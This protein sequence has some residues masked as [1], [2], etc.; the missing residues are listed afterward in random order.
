MRGEFRYMWRLA[1]REPGFVAI[2]VMGL[3]I[4]ADA[5]RLRR[6]IPM[7]GMKPV[8]AGLAAGILLSLAVGRLLESLLFRVSPRNPATIVIVASVLIAVAAA[9]C[10]LPACRSTRVNPAVALR[11]E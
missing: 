8:A 9:A 4:G 10:T 7:Q 5:S 2:V 11:Y 6:M 3:A 1:R